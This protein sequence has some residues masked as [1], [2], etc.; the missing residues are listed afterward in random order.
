M[1]K[2]KLLTLIMIVSLFTI[3]LE[4]KAQKMTGI[5]ITPSFY[6]P[7]I[8]F[9]QWVN[10]KIGWGLEGQTNWG[11]S[12]IIARGRFM[13]GFHTSEKTRY[14]GLLSVGYMSINDKDDGYEFSVSAPSAV[15]GVGA[16][17][18]IGF[19]KNK[20]LGLELGYQYGQA[21]YDMSIDTGYGTFSSTSTYKLSPV[22][23]AGTFSFYFG[24]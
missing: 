21:D 20:G 24:K 2:V 3:S 13:Y 19:K 11:F 14:Y 18:L 10:P 15:I 12:D 22:Y 6:G 23:I 5:T 8:G 7:A 9:R 1:K 4:S 16:E 17:W